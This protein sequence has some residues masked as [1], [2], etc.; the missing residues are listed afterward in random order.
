MH[1]KNALV[2]FF[3][4]VPILS[5]SQIKIDNVGDGWGAKVDSAISLI[6]KTDLERYEVLIKNCNQVEFIIG[7]YSTTKPPSVIAIT[8]KD[9]NRGSIN[10]IAAILVHESYHLKLWNEGIKIDPNKEEREAYIW[11]YEFLCK[12]PNVEDWLFLHAINQIIRY[13]H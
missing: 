10:N 3:M 6:K 11:E 7:D 9:M 2:T 13:S 5:F 8:T 12:L 4:I 1:I